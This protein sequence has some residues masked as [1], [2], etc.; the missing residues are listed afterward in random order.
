MSSE[1]K[2]SGNISQHIMPTASTLL[3]ICFAMLGYINVMALKEKTL[4]DE[5]LAI[6]TVLF[7]GATISSYLS[8][9]SHRHGQLYEQIADIIFLCGLGLLTVAAV[10]FTFVI[11]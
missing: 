9:R 7:F 8:M 11:I 2:E 6:A 10:V 4:L 3:G 1:K 5:I